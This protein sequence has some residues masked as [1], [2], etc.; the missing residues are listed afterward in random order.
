MTAALST[1][2]RDF[3]L[4]EGSVKDALNLGFINLYTTPVP[5]H[6]DDAPTGSLLCT[7]SVNSS[8]TGVTLGAAAN[9]IIAKN[10]SEIW[11]GINVA[12]GSA[13]YF[14]WVQA[15]DT[16]V[17]STTEKRIQ[18]TCGVIGADL[19]MSSVTLTN[20]APQ[21]IDA[22]NIIIPEFA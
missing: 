8:G 16:G 7:V 13:A 19:N 22:A 5:A 10:A 14:R 20:G 11:S 18:G 17:A 3:M 15:G 6:G 12:S 9:G 2:M 21:L 1:A 4:D